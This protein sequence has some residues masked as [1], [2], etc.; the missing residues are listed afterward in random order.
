VPSRPSG[1]PIICPVCDGA[2][3]REILQSANG[4]PIVRCLDCSL[5][6]T[7]DRSAPPPSTLYPVFD[8]SDTTVRRQARSA[9]NVFLH[10]RE[11][12]VRSAKP[13]GRLL[14]FGCGNG[15]FARWM[16]AAGYDVVGLEPFSLGAT[17][18]TERLTLYRQPL[19]SVAAE[20][21]AF[22]VITLWQVLE[23]M[24]RPVSVLRDLR[25]HLR[26]GGILIVSVPNFRS[27]QSR[28]FGRQWFHLDPP[29]H[30]IHFESRTLDRCLHEAGLERVAERRFLPEYGSSGWVQSPLN[31]ILPHTNYLYELMK[32]RGA[33]HGMSRLNKTL[34]LLISLVAGAPL[35]LVSLPIEA[36]ASLMG[37]G[38][39]L[40]YVTRSRETS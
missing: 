35:L 23:H 11:A 24:A 33:L 21:G 5:A 28:F 6:F 3:S 1:D 36:A 37:W 20:L 12:V 30:L 32:D 22:D 19:E 27:W 9:L 29:R 38:A 26:P 34:H 4:Y 31:L 15:A 2:R 39:A 16:N 13:A 18:A 7:D 14:D 17:T 10:Q 25:R 40:T 8:Q